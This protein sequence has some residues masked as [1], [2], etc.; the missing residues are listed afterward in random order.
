MTEILLALFLK[1]IVV[2]VVAK[3]SPGVRIEGFGSAVAVAAVFALLTWAL[4]GLLV[5]MLWP[6]IFMTLGLALLAMNAFLLWLTDKIV[7]TFHVKNLGGLILAT[8]G[9][10]AGT[11]VVEHIVPKLV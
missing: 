5:T 2:V 8:V 11:L 4:K 10:S 3:V 7:P 9:I 1:A 6:S